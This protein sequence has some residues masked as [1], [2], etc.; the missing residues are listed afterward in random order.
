MMTG[1]V[2]PESGHRFSNDELKWMSR[3]LGELRQ[4]VSERQIQRQMLWIG[5]AIGLMVHV[6]GFL[7][8]SSST[9]EPIA[10]LADL[11]YTLGWALWTGVV[12]IAVVEIIPAAKER[13]I[14]RALD[15]YELALRSRAST[16]N[17]AT[18]SQDTNTQQSG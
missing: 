2:D 15:A 7:L 14:S 1:V 8:K 16:N 4:S 12:V 6:A 13:Q 10:L 5:L 18:V 3:H 17:A 9:G 11:L